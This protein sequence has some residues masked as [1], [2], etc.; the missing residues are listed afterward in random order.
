V[1]TRARENEKKRESK[2]AR[3]RV[4][5]LERER[6]KER[7]EG[8]KRGNDIERGDARKHERVRMRVCVCR[9]VYTKAIVPVHSC[10]C[11]Q[12]RGRDGLKMDLNVQ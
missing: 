9:G 2:R 4:R 3:V 12:E 10:I 11:L 7:K 5:E 6:E 1:H 8:G